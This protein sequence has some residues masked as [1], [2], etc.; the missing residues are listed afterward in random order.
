VLSPHSDRRWS[1][2]DQN[3]LEQI[4]RGVAPILQQ[5]QQDQTLHDELKK[6][7][8]N[9][10][11]IQELL[12]NAQAQNEALQIELNERPQEIAVERPAQKFTKRKTNP[13]V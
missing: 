13:T 3:Y 5:T 8:E 9:L 4:A 2:E 10:G 1:R 7:Q 12:E 6:A 11:S